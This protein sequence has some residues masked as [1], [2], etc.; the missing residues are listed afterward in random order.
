MNTEPLDTHAELIKNIHKI[1][2]QSEE[3]GSTVYYHTFKEDREFMKDI[4]R[5]FGNHV[6]RV[7]KQF[8][9]ELKYS[10]DETSKTFSDNLVSMLKRHVADKIDLSELSEITKNT[11]DKYSEVD[12]AKKCINDLTY[13]ALDR[14]F[15]GATTYISHILPGINKESNKTELNRLRYQYSCTPPEYKRYIALLSNM[16]TSS[17][18]RWK[19]ESLE[20]H[21]DSV[22]KKID[23][24]F[25]DA[26]QVTEELLTN[27]A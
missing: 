14:R 18:G 17:S 2:E 4:L 16:E 1:L 10:E 27:K 21:A 8:R 22:Y 5:L 26:I 25:V 23:A 24:L 19:Y 20:R 6:E 13:D 9:D 7:S 12:K 11:L 3:D 15:T